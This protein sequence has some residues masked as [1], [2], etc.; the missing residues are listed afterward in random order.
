MADQNRPGPL[1][2]IAVRRWVVVALWVAVVAA[3]GA[4]IG[5]MLAD[6]LLPGDPWQQFQSTRHLGDFREVVWTPGRF[7]LDGGN[8]Y[9]PVTYLA[10]HPWAQQFSPYPPVWLLLGMALGPLPFLVSAGIFQ[11][12]AV[13]VAVLTVRVICTWAL[14]RIA[15]VAVPVGV[16][17]LNVWYPGR[18][19]LA[20]LGSVLVV[21]GVALVLRSVTRPDAA[22][23][24][25]GLDRACVAGV[26]IA[27]VKPQF[28]LLVLLVA[29][30]GGRLREAWRGVVAI[31]L[32]CVPVLVAVLVAAGGPSAFLASLQRNLAHL[33]GTD[34]TGGLT[35]PFQRRFDMLGGLAHFGLTSPP[36]WAFVAVPALAL[37]VV[38]LVARRSRDPFLLSAVV[39]TAAL[40]GFYHPW[41]DVVVMII[42][43]ALGIGMALRGELTGLAAR[44]ALA[45]SVFVVGHLHSVSTAL[46]PGLTDRAAD[47][48]DFVAVVAVLAVATAGA[49]L[50]AARHEPV[51]P[52][53]PAHP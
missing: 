8:P 9:D 34:S 27:L 30:V 31:T 40:L 5:T 37:L 19:A 12:L 45:L 36:G 35:S 47:T 28:G 15:D 43:V 32:G 52:T 53:V 17:W 20:S 48:I 2:R 23:V 1:G 46:V 51:E 39:C 44:I 49:L 25:P 13:G 33:G 24:R 21:L 4:R 6:P 22:G 11:V 16:L 50:A 3:A 29:A 18:G 10:A 38:V 42:P 41:Y 7:L 26:A 14:P